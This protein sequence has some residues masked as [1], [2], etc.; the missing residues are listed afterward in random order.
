MIQKAKLTIDGDA[1]SMDMPIVKV[2]QE[3]RL[4][5][6]FA[7]LDNVDSQGDI[8]TKEA[9]MRAF[10]QF[11]GNIREMHQ[12][13][14]VGKVVAYRP[15]TYVDPTS[16]EAYNGIYVSA[17]VSKGAQDT[18]EKVLDGTLTGFSIGGSIKKSEPLFIEEAD[19]I[20][21][22][23]S[24]YELSELSLVDNPANKFANVLFIQKT[25]TGSE[26]I[27]KSDVH[28]CDKDGILTVQNEQSNCPLC[29]KSMQTIGFIEEEP[30]KEVLKGILVKFKTAVDEV[31]KSTE[32]PKEEIMAEAEPTVETQVDTELTK[33]V[34]ASVEAV[35]ELAATVGS[36][37]SIVDVVKSL[38]ESV[39]ELKKSFDTSI[40]EVSE[41]V[42]DEVAKFDDRVT[43]V[44]AD[45]AV[46]KSG[47]V[48]DVAEIPVKKSVWNGAFLGAARVMK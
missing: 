17:F 42:K 6:G 38:S 32:N 41:T 8:V 45:T 24:D 1:I 15:D 40:A 21:R 18:W 5:S 7:T 33:A 12:P 19:S 29:N 9:S 23:V 34:N 4:V 2:D 31:A 11:R 36:L 14:A 10:Q 26:N 48:G 39:A 37:A 13:K 16:G 20:Y 27:V 44:E 3:N 22:K 35:K 25:N 46:R 47:D 28:W 30:T 43:A